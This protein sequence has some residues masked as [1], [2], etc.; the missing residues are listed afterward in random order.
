[1]VNLNIQLH[2]RGDGEE[3]FITLFS[4]VLSKEARRQGGE[5]RPG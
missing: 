3:Q 2:G 1:M 4:L 5:K